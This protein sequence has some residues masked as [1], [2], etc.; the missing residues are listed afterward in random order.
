M[1]KNQ[2]GFSLILLFLI[3]LIVL[4]VGLVSWQVLSKENSQPKKQTTIQQSN[5][6]QK[7]TGVPK[8]VTKTYCSDVCPQ[9]NR[10]FQVYYGINSQ[11]ECD[12]INGQTIEDAAWGGYIG[13]RAKLENQ[14]SVVKE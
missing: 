5:N 11:A 8:I 14:P 1:K 10:T 6:K 9:Y 3:L 12:K 7:G 4:I 2:N 13:C